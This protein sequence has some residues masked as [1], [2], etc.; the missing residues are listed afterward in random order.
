[1]SNH[2]SQ[3]LVRI[4]IETTRRGWRL[5]RNS[6]A[7]AWVG[8]KAGELAGGQ[9]GIVL[10]GARRVTFGLAPGAS[11]LVGWRPVEISQDMVGQTL[12]QFVS[13]E[14]KTKAYRALTA[15]QR[16][17]LQAV[18]AAGGVALVGEIKDGKI[19]FQNMK[20]FS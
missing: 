10:Q 12:A 17:W 2:E 19:I 7:V 1:M 20:D 4:L 6:R 15:E 16:A 3:D 14:V 9:R 11:D 8:K 18:E 5:F 13:V